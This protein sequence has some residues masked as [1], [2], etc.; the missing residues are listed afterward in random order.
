MTMQSGVLFERFEQA[1]QARELALFGVSLLSR[2][3]SVSYGDLRFTTLVTRSLSVKNGDVDRVTDNDDRGFGVRLVA[4]GAWGFA[5][6]NELTEEAVARAVLRAVEVAK[7][8][9]AL[10]GRRVELCE[11]EPVVAD[12]VEAVAED[13]LAV[14]LGRSLDLMVRASE[15]MTGVSPKVKVASAQMD[16]SGHGRLFASTEGSLIRQYWHQTGGE[17]SA[18]AIDG[19]GL[20]VRSW[21]AS[22]GG[23]HVRGGYEFIGA[24]DFPG[25]AGRVAGEAVELLSAPPCPVGVTDL[26]I[27]SSQ[28]ALQIH[29]SC[30]HPTELDRVI[31]DEISLAGGSFLGL[32]KRGRFRYGSPLVNIVAD[33]TVPGALGSF[34]YD[35]EGVPGARFHLVRDGLFTGYLASRETAAMVGL[36]RSNGTMRADGWGNFPLIRMTNIN[37]EP[38]AGTLEDLVADVKQ[39]VYVETN[40]SWSIDDLRLNFQFG[41]ELGREIRNGKL[42]GLLRNPVYTGVTPQFWGSCDGIAGPGDWQVWGIPNC[43]KG[44]PLQTAHVGHG[45]SPARFRGVQVG[46]D[47]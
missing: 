23:N 29:E 32:E 45:A 13:P 44:E 26:V 6:S 10:G 15:R 27:D 18:T 19:D 21:P 7:T 30:G 38:G 43:G 24:M 31:G 16:F 25:Q 28:M 36:E 35:D 33:A 42:G 37:L 2:N 3:D 40:R 9:A 47:S 46:V 17:I 5:A 39:G 11:I 41:T 14:P 8:S 20:Q 34:A 22:M 1:E 4:D 12:H